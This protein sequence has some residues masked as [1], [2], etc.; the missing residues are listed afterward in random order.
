LK[1]FLALGDPCPKKAA[2]TNGPS[3][4][5]TERPFD[6]FTQDWKKESGKTSSY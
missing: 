6:Y 1:I 3:T 4:P 2:K 5:T